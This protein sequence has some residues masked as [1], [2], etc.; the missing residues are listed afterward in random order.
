MK[1]LKRLNPMFNH[2][3][4]RNE[5]KLARQRIGR[6]RLAHGYHMSK[7]RPPEYE[8]C[9]KLLTVKHILIDC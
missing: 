7:G 4:R 1:G 6:Y 5:V 3:K 9:G 2:G 8:L